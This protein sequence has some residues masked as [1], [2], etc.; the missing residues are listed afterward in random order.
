MILIERQEKQRPPDHLQQEEIVAI[1]QRIPRIWKGVAN[2]IKLFETYE[3]DDIIYS[4]GSA[5][6]SHKARTMLARYIER[7][8]TRKKLADALEELKMFPLAK[9]VSSGS[10]I[11][12]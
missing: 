7:G 8:G 11:R 3:I 12:D 9:D 10:F 5:D 6:E 4:G 2:L 1:A